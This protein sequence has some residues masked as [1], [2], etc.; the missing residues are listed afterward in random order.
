M[1]ETATKVGFTPGPWRIWEPEIDPGTNAV[2]GIIVGKRRKNDCEHE[3]ATINC[4]SSSFWSEPDD[5]LIRSQSGICV[6]T[7]PTALANARLIAAAPD[8]LAACEAV[9][10]DC[11]RVPGR[12]YNGPG[13]EPR[14]E[15][16]EFLR[17]AIAKATGT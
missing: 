7:K 2:S 14:Y 1:N 15:T 17:A 9:L 4:E 16:M 11:T 12:I 3:I 10:A 6:Y 5:A 8:L 13:L